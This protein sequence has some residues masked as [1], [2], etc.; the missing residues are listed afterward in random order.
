MIFAGKKEQAKE[1]LW[2]DLY[3]V[4]TGA[5]CFTPYISEAAGRVR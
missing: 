5:P 2:G 1:N 3:A 4:I